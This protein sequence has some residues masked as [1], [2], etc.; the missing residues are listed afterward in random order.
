M[1]V[2]ATQLRQQIEQTRAALATKLDLLERHVSRKG[3]AVLEQ[4]VIGPVSGIQAAVARD[5]SALRQTPW[6]IMAVGGLLGYAG[7]RQAGL[8]PR[9]AA[10]AIATPR[11]AFPSA[12]HAMAAVSDARQE[13]PAPA[14]APSMPGG[15]RRRRRLTRAPP[16]GSSGA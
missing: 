13:P 6:L 15:P 16:L 8:L 14:A 10:R 12:A 2:Q 5:V 1:D 3:A 7:A 11:S 4:A 9:P